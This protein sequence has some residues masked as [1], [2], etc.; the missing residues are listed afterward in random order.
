MA[1]EVLAEAVLSNILYFIHTTKHIRQGSAIACRNFLMSV[2]FHKHKFPP[3]AHSSRKISQL[4]KIH[5]NTL[6]S[7]MKSKQCLKDIRY[8]PFAKGSASNFWGNRAVSFGVN[9]FQFVRN[10]RTTYHV[11]SVKYR[12]QMYWFVNRVEQLCSKKL[13]LTGVTTL[14]PVQTKKIWFSSTLKGQECMCT[15]S[16]Q[17]AERSTS[18]AKEHNASLIR[19]IL[20]R[21]PQRLSISTSCSSTHWEEV[22]TKLPF[23]FNDNIWSVKQDVCFFDTG[24]VTFYLYRKLK[25]FFACKPSLL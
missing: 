11:P 17:T 21:T 8:K 10:Y 1:R 19:D 20:W 16:S 25:P 3:Q 24:I 14:S 13:T 2:C 7:H 22:L 6:L 18:A 5:R 23:F 12:Y 4:T 9:C 15:F